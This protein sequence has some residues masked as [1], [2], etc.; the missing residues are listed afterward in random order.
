MKETK[1]KQDR[2]VPYFPELSAI[3]GSVTSA[4]LLAQLS[5]W[6]DRKAGKTLYKTDQDLAIELGFSLKTLRGAKQKLK[7]AMLV[8]IV[9]KGIPR[10]THYTAIE[11]I[12]DLITLTAAKR[13]NQGDQKRQKSS[14]KKACKV[15][16]KGQTNSCNT[17]F[18]TQ[19]TSTDTTST[20][21]TIQAKKIKTMR[22][23][24][25]LGRW[26]AVVDKNDWPVEL[27]WHRPSQDLDRRILTAID[28]FGGIDELIDELLHRCSEIDGDNDWR[29]MHKE[30]GETFPV[31][32]AYLLNE[33]YL[34]KS[35]SSR[36]APVDQGEASPQVAP[37]PVNH[38]AM[39][40]RDTAQPISAPSISV[41]PLSNGDKRTSVCRSTPSSDRNPGRVSAELESLKWQKNRELSHTAPIDG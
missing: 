3:T 38:A 36:F 34:P 12:N 25:F 6:W 28:R 26:Q 7:D 15:E 17:Q 41:T 23:N 33:L 29:M 37:A 31:N 24:S 35:S 9:L 19:N 1:V 40:H 5:Y 18:N 21:S 20:L 27:T 8:K 22:L 4:I 10:K 30:Y 13:S 14:V 16:Q 32:L 2:K 11:D 39:Q